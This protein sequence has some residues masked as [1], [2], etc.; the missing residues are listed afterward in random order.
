MLPLSY[1]KPW[2]YRRSGFLLVTVRPAS[3]HLLCWC[4]LM[5]ICPHQI[6]ERAY[7]INV[8]PLK[9]VMFSRKVTICLWQGFWSHPQV[10]QSWH[11]WMLSDILM[12]SPHALTAAHIV[13]C[14]ACRSFWCIQW[15]MFSGEFSIQCTR[16]NVSASSYPGD[17]K[18]RC[19]EAR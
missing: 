16:A 18:G 2:W 4:K 7:I 19:P 9:R 8:S 6:A 5:H 1:L 14:P 3:V 10:S 13:F 17:C 15:V 12:G 11:A